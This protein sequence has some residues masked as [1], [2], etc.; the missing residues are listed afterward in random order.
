MIGSLSP[1]SLLPEQ[2]AGPFGS[3]DELKI[4]DMLIGG[5]AIRTPYL[6]CVLRGFDTPA[7]EDPSLGWTQAGI[8]SSFLNLRDLACFAEMT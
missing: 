3:S 7:G 1:G 4:R 6:G 2:P 5:T 8:C